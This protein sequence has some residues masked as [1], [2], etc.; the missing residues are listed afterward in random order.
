MT[1]KEVRKLSRL[2]LLEILVEQANEIEQLKAELKETKEQ[3]ADR[4]IVIF[5]CMLR[6]VFRVW[7]CVERP[8]IPP[9]DLPAERVCRTEPCIRN[10]KERGGRRH[11]RV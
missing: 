1:E 3:L 8:G 10:R 11:H 2:Q 7:L 4:K 9:A 5:I 6:R